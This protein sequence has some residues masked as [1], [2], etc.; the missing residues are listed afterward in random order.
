MKD[1]EFIDPI[2][3]FLTD[4]NSNVSGK[5]Q[6]TLSDLFRIQPVKKL[7]DYFEILQ[8]LAEPKEKD[9]KKRKTGVLGLMSLMET[10]QHE[11]RG[12]MEKSLRLILKGKKLTGIKEKLKT[13]ASNFL[14][15]TF[16]DQIHNLEDV[17]SEDTLCDLREISNPYNYFA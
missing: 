11:V 9:E 13:F 14:K 1:I 15:Q 10:N 7:Q 8:K 5:A 2:L 12:Y 4:E 16:A 6:K 17:V 3:E